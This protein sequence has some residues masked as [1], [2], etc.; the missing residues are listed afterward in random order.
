M[1]YPEHNFYFPH[2][3]C[4][5]VGIIFPRWPADVLVLSCWVRSAGSRGNLITAFQFCTHS[6]HLININE[7]TAENEKALITYFSPHV[8]PALSAADAPH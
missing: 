3:V 5:C 2:R 4:V 6:L 8:T 1:L 7:P